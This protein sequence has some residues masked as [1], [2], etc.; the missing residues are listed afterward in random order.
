MPSASYP[1]SG[2]NFTQ[3]FGPQQLV[4][5]TTLC[6]NWA[7]VQSIYASDC[8]NT[9]ISNVFGTGNPTYNDAYWNITYVRTYEVQ[10]NATSSSISPA[11]S[12]T[13][14]A[15]PN[16]VVT[17]TTTIGSNPSTS[18]TTGSTQGNGAI[19]L[20]HHAVLQAIL[21]VA[22]LVHVLTTLV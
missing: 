22:A 10:A 1:A 17:L 21:G 5:D 15:S 8:P 3:F 7:G 20:V 13:A 6:G 2:C 9:C 4:L 11:G 14:E 18:T 19:R 16:P 12:V